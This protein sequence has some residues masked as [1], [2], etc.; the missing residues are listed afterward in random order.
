ME[1]ANSAS[2]MKLFNRL[3]DT[4]LDSYQQAHGQ[5]TVEERKEWEEGLNLVGFQLASRAPMHHLLGMPAFSDTIAAAFTARKFG[6]QFAFIDCPAGLRM[7]DEAAIKRGG[8]EM[9]G[10][11]GVSACAIDKGGPW[12]KL[13]CQLS[14]DG[15]V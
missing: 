8:H 4:P 15:G 1:A 2:M 13:V 6:A 5:L 14:A 7:S 11:R 10:E 12:Q 9:R 3:K